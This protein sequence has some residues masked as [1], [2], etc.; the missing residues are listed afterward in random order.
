VVQPADP[1]RGFSEPVRFSSTPRTGRRARSAPAPSPR[2]GPRRSPR[3]ARSRRPAAAASSGCG[4][5]S[6]CRRRSVRAAEDA[7][8]LD[9]Q[10]DS[11]KR[12]DVAIALAQPDGLDGG[13]GL[14]AFY[15]SGRFSSRATRIRPMRPL[16]SAMPGAV[17]RTGVARQYGSDSGARAHRPTWAGETFG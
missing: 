3:P 17:S 11:A 2:R 13:A 10:I 16:S 8:R 9:A 5:P 7:A 4:R 14:H 15:A 6:S 1:A 12:M